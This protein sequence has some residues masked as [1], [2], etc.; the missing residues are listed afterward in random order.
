MH[1]GNY[2][3]GTFHMCSYSYIPDNN[4]RY[5]LLIKYTGDLLPCYM[6]MHHFR[7]TIEKTDLETVCN[8][9]D[10]LINW[11]NKIH[12]IVNK[13]LDKPIVSL[14]QA[15]KLYMNNDIPKIDHSILAGYIDTI[16]QDNHMNMII[17]EKKI[18]TIENLCYI[19]PCPDCR[20]KLINYIT[21]NN[22]SKTKT[23]IWINNILKIINSHV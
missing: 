4:K 18:K 21:N 22:G 23:N 8:S 20:E 14:S 2:I 17:K 10:N 6:C 15:E 19:F 7:K 9:R 1:W 5:I 13:R 11:F 16:S 12:N 3:W